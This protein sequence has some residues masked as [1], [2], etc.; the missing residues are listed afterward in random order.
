MVRSVPHGT[1]PVKFSAAPKSKDEK[2]ARK[3]QDPRPVPNIACP[4]FF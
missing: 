4:H 1:E 3:K 2:N